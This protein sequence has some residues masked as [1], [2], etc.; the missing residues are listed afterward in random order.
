MARIER[1]IVIERTW[2]EVDAVALDGARTPEWYA[3]VESASADSVYPQV[4][5]SVK[6]VY[7][8][9]MTTFT[10][11][12]TTREYAPGSFILFDIEGGVIRG[13]SRW[14]HAPVGDGTRLTCVLDYETL[15]GGLGAIADKLLLE[16]MNTE[17]LEKSLSNLKALVER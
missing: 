6:M 16:R 14:S 11:T 10:L 4:G 12:Q 7:K 13:T 2:Q 1:S 17:Q 5:G 9:A 3:G 15:G 8:A